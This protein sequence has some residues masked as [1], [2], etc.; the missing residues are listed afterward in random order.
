MMI[1]AKENSLRPKSRALA[2]QARSLA[3]ILREEFGSP[4][5][6][7]D[8]VSGSLFDESG[9]ISDR[10]LGHQFNP[11]QAGK[12]AALLRASVTPMPGARY[13]VAIPLCLKEAP[14]LL[15]I[16]IIS[17]CGESSQP[18]P[19]ELA[20]LQKWSQ[21]VADR[22][23]LSSSV[24]MP[25]RRAGEPEGGGSAALEALAGLEQLLRRVRIHKDPEKNQRRILREAV[26]LLGAGAAVWVPRQEDAEAVTWGESV[27]SAWDS[28]QI[29]TRLARNPDLTG[30]GYVMMNDFQF[31]SLGACFPQ[32]QNLLAISV[33][34]HAQNG[35]LL[36][37]NKGR[38]TNETP[39]CSVQ[40]KTPVAFRR[41]DVLA[42]S[43]F[44]A[45]LALQ[46]DSSGRFRDM[47]D[48]LVGLVRSLTASIDAKDHY[49]FGH[50]ERV[51]RIAVEIG[52]ELGYQ[53]DEINDLYLAG[54]LHDIGKIG[55]RDDVLCKKTFLSPEELE[56]IQQHVVIGHSI[57]AD[58][59]PLRHLLP[60]VLYHHERY[61]G[62]GY[63]QQL[64]GEAIPIIARILAVADAYDAMCT[65]RPYREAMPADK[66]E[67][68]LRQG[69]GT[70]WD[71]NI[72]DA[73]MRG[74]PKIHAV[75]QRGIGESL[76]HAVHGALRGQQSILQ[77]DS[78]EMSPSSLF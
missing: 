18:S 47:K 56:H 13:Q 26:R 17:T 65:S 33:N 7:Y 15:G 78:G 3:I 8:S 42:V 44:A 31:D 59:H 67:S 24:P 36:I 11:D 23:M 50:S 55:I 76:R 34:D 10:K 1:T 32:I 20:R 73:F 62:G 77:G 28:R 57:L 48:L 69:A 35:V 70:Q 16:G 37:L 29:T 19:L 72:V 52:R 61:D 30:A 45:L 27:L 63:P 39:A 74:L 14:F 4:F 2:L 58:L 5:E 68:I 22:L 40:E 6:I 51:G 53:A 21:S 46:N 66:A 60:G 49:T 38:G 41:S 64:K 9:E 43:P 54:L 75:R 71:R 25:S 12:L